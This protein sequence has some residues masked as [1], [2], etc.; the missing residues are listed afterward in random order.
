MV[1]LKLKTQPVMT[2]YKCIEIF[3]SDTQE[4]GSF[5]LTKKKT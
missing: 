4:K 5:V 3:L 2:I 1:L